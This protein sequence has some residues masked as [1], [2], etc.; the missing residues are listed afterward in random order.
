MGAGAA[1]EGFTP[2]EV[3]RLG[4]IG[5]WMLRFEIPQPLDGP[6]AIAALE[7]IEPGSTAGVNHAY[8]TAAVSST[9]RL[10]YAS[11][12]M[13]WPETACPAAGP[14]GMLDTG[15][16]S[17]LAQAT[18]AR[19]LGESFAR[20]APAPSRHGTDVAALLVDPRRLTGAT[21]YAADVIGTSARGQQEAGVDSLLKALDWLAAQDV[22]LVNISLAGPYNKLLDRGVDRAVAEGMTLVAAVGN[23]GAGAAPRYPAALPNVIAVTAVDADRRI[24]RRAVRGPHVDAAAPGVD[25][26][27]DEGGGHFVSGTSMAVPFVTARIAADP[28]LYTAPTA[29]IRRRLQDSAQD[30]GPPGRDTVYGAGLVVAGPGC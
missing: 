2:R 19:I 3:T 24:Y 8:R 29:M 1:A 21:L 26:Y 10:D 22:R 4:G 6:G 11:A 7:T 25:I 27:V 9:D 30:L 15:V 13:N 12:L 23:D 17:A 16:D 28:G 5:L 14:I 20:G 18:G